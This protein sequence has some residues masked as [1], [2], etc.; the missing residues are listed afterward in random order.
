MVIKSLQHLSLRNFSIL[1]SIYYLL[2]FFKTLKLAASA[3]ACKNYIVLATCSVAFILRKREIGDAAIPGERRIHISPSPPPQ[4]GSLA[5]EH[6][7]SSDV[8]L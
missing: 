1:L 2:Y 4:L 3:I 7:V 6:A 8:T 5:N